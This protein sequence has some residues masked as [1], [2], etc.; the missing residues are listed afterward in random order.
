MEICSF[1]AVKTKGV[2][3]CI[4]IESNIRWIVKKLGCW[5]HSYCREER[6]WDALTSRV[7]MCCVCPSH[8]YDSVFFIGDVFL[9]Q[10][11]WTRYILHGTSSVTYA[12]GPQRGTKWIGHPWRLIL[13]QGIER[14][15]LRMLGIKELS[16]SWDYLRRRKS[17]FRQS[18]LAQRDQLPSK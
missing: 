8:S 17:V 18:W 11:L 5:T 4:F 15:V 3:S 12:K 7:Y 14:A 13:I 2:L 1:F 10:S 6:I 16:F 9:S